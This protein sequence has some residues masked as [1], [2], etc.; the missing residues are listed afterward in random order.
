M[1]GRWGT[2]AMDDDRRWGLSFKYKNPEKGF[3]NSGFEVVHASSME[4]AAKRLMRDRGLK[5]ITIT[6]LR[7]REGEP[8]SAAEVIN[9][10]FRL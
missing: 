6:K 9:K 10:T 7:G 8:A 3:E 5:E 2:L 4:E 1:S